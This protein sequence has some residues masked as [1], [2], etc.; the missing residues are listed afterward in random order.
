MEAYTVVALESREGIVIPILDI[1]APLLV[2]VGIEEQ[3]VGKRL[4]AAQRSR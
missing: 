1:V 2:R 3:K 4:R